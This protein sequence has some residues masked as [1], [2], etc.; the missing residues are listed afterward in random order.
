LAALLP[1]LPSPVNILSL[2]EVAPGS[3]TALSVK[4]LKWNDI[5][6]LQFGLAFQKYFN[7]LQS[8]F[9]SDGYLLKLPR[10]DVM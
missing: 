5:L 4:R 1:P 3:G 8:S 10:G 2:A 6:E 7:I 9:L